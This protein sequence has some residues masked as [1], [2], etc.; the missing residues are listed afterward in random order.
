M[1]SSPMLDPHPESQH[2]PVWNGQPTLNLPAQVDFPAPC[3]INRSRAFKGP[4]VF[5]SD[6]YRPPITER[7]TSL[8]PMDE[9]PIFLL[10]QLEGRKRIFPEKIVGKSVGTIAIQPMYPAKI[11]FNLFRCGN[12]NITHYKKFCKF[13]KKLLVNFCKGFQH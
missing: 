2:C 5:I 10:I 6:Y 8:V 11:S 7:D 12:S 3:F 9:I 1:C 4:R 13:L